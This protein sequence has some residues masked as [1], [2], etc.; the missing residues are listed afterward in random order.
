MFIE[1][2]IRRDFPEIEEVQFCGVAQLAHEA[3]GVTLN[4]KLRDFVPPTLQRVNDALNGAYA[5][6]VDELFDNATA[7]AA[8]YQ[9]MSTFPLSREIHGLWR[10]V[11]EQFKPGDEYTLVDRVAETL[12]VRAWYAWQ[13]DP[14]G[15]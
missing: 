1:H 7:Y 10:E 5:L 9:A 4:E 11:V 12:G 3:L 2:R 13:D 15:R 14:A 8:H 6:F